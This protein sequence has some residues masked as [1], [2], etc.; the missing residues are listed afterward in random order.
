MDSITYP[1]SASEGVDA[2]ATQ[3]VIPA[4][5]SLQKAKEEVD[6]L[7]PPTPDEIDEY[8]NQS[9]DPFVL[10]C[11]LELRELTKKVNEIEADLNEF[12]LKE[13]HSPGNDSDRAKARQQFNTA[14]KK[15]ADALDGLC[16]V[17]TH[18][19]QLDVV[20]WAEVLRSSLPSLK[21]P[22]KNSNTEMR[23]WL[24]EN[25]PEAGIKTR[26]KIPDKW[27]QKWYER[28]T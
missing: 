16:H 17:A 4:Y 22:T 15:T 3:H 5:T 23:A 11:F 19:G 14:K 21:S 18:E 7:R 20:D 26:G 27:A 12:A 6:R 24:Q 9:Q 28:N 2:L 8:L 25:F 10:Q 1:G 13:L